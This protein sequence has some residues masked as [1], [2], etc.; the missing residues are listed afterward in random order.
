MIAFNNSGNKFKKGMKSSDDQT[1][2]ID[3]KG[4][5][6]L[7][8]TIT[9]FLMALSFFDT[10]D[11]TSSIKIIIFLSIGI[12]SLMLFVVIERRSELSY[13]QFTVVDKQIYHFSQ[14]H[15]STDLPY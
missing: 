8:A 2:S 14:Y 4:V 10:D 11:V 6:A 7:S 9:S 12:I 15:P 3:V 13:T 5:I 1:R